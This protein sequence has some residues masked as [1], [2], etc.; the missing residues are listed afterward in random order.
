[1]CLL[2]KETFSHIY[3]CWEVEQIFERLV[4]LAKQLG[5]SLANTAQMR[6]LGLTPQESVLPGTISDLHII[7]WKFIISQLATLVTALH[8]TR[9]PHTVVMRGG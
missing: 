4:C 3:S 9:P 7:I 6:V 5:I 1:M 8:A 2:E